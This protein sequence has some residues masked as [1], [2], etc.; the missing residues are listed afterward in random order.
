MKSPI[1]FPMQKNTR[2]S[3]TSKNLFLH[4]FQ[5]ILFITIPKNLLVEILLMHVK[6]NFIYFS[7]IDCTGHG[8]PG[9]LMSMIGNSLLNEMIVEKGLIKTN[10]ILDAVSEKLKSSFSS[11]N[12]ENSQR[13]NGYDL[14]RLNISNNELMYSGAHNSMVIASEGKLHEYKG[15]RRPVGLF[16][17][18]NFIFFKNYTIE[19]EGRYLF[20][21]RWF[22]GPIWRR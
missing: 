1:V 9:A 20:I 18:G 22:C 19:K 21:Y 5:I 14:C 13:W 11:L 12:G 15:D 3:F 7:V 6:E 8:V 10:K 17:K 16:R 4:I 2:G